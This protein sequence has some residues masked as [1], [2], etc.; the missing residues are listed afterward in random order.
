MEHPCI[1]HAIVPEGEH[2]LT[3]TLFS[4][5]TANS[6][7]TEPLVQAH[8]NGPPFIPV[9]ISIEKY[10]LLWC[11]EEAFKGPV[12]NNELSAS[13]GEADDLL[14]LNRG[15]NSE[16]IIEENTPLMTRDEKKRVQVKLNQNIRQQKTQAAEGTALKG[17]IKKR[18]LESTHDAILTNYSLQEKVCVSAPGWIGKAPQ[19]LAEKKGLTCFEWNGQ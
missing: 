12:T 10:L 2:L 15:S 5:N 9:P 11:S 7:E 3:Y 17:V 1:L 6:Y 14:R 19:G 18:W 16:E 4:F 8:P 13:D